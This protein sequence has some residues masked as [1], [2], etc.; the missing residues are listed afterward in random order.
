MSNDRFIPGR[1]GT[2]AQPDTGTPRAE[3]PSTAAEATAAELRRDS[4]GYYVQA[5]TAKVRVDGA[6]IRSVLGEVAIPRPRPSSRRVSIQPLAAAIAAAAK[7]R[8]RLHQMGALAVRAGYLFRAGKITNT[9]CVVVAFA[10]GNECAARAPTDLDGV[11][12]DVVAADPLEQMRALGTEAAALLSSA[13]IPLIESI[14]L[15]DDESTEAVPA[16]TYE[17]PRGVR[18]DPVTA[19]MTII[20]CVSPDAGW[21]VLKPFLLA[22]SESMVLGMYDFTAPHIYT[23]IRSALKDSAVTWTQTLGPKESLPAEDDVDSTKAGDF[24]EDKIVRGLKRAAGSRFTSTFARTGAGQTFASAYHIK[25]AVRDQSAF[26]LSSGNWQSSNQPDYDFLAADADRRLIPKYNREWHVVIENKELAKTFQAFLEHDYR[27]ALGRPQEEAAAV[28]MP[29]VLVPVS[30]FLE[31]EEA[32]RV[33][34]EVFPPLKRTFTRSRPAT[35]Q[36]I[37]TPDNYL[38][39]VLDLL[40][41]RPAKKLYFQNQ[42]LN[43]VKAPT[44]EFAE[45]MELLAEYSRDESLDVRMIFRNIGPVRKKLESLQLAG[46]NM[47]RVRIQAGCHTKG[48]VVDS[49]IVLLGSHNVTNQGVQVNRD[50]SILIEDAPM[51]EYYERIFLH[52]WEKLAKETVRTESG[53]VVDGG[54]ESEAAVEDGRFV[55]VPWA[56]Y[57]GG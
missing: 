3:P 17:P 1:D 38:P 41:R 2:D 5:G 43:P 57:F 56:E 36:P 26:W 7:H 4:H 49:K 48:I 24:T 10:P 53:A 20:C 39:V 6:S 55:R 42:S 34:L 15:P 12:C 45:L 21:S 25:V 22:T 9:P 47:D 30:E 27:T 13:D 52:D 44:E 46:F 8:A 37:L 54:T 19:A 11:P 51:A 33:D 14:Q 50:A 18:L 23:A 31:A 29:D 16:I 40:R 32:A 28:A 35:V